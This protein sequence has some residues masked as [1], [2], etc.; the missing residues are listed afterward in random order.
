MRR[1]ATT[2]YPS[3]LIPV[4]ISTAILTTRPCSRTFTTNASAAAGVAAG[5]CA[6]ADG[7]DRRE[8]AVCIG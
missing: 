7:G 5:V 2:R 4:A 1:R 3:A 6:A 8:P